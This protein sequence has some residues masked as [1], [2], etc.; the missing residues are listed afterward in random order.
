MRAASIL[1]RHFTDSHD[2]PGPD[3]E[4]SMD[5]AELKVMLEGSAT[6]F[7]ARGGRKG[8]LKEEKVTS[9]FAFASV[10]MIAD[11]KAGESLSEHTLWVKRPG[12][13]DFLAE[14]YTSLL[15]RTVARD[16][17]AG[18]QLQRADLA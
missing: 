13:G 16:V 15:G 12:T 11:V 6:I 14:D 17:K 7:K 2:R 10:V 18:A 9:D 8:A 1:E 5:P 3:I 4:C